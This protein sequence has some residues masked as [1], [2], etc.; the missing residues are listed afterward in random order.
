MA[1][2]VVS[3]V[4]FLC[5]VLVGRGVRAERG[6]LAQTATE[7]V[8]P[9]PAADAWGGS[10]PAG[11]PS[12]ST[13][14]ARGDELSYFNRSRSQPRRWRGS[15]SR[16][17][18]S[19]SRSVRRSRPTGRTRRCRIEP[20]PA[21]CRQSQSDPPSR[22]PAAAADHQTA[23]RRGRCRSGRIGFCR[24]G[25]R[26]ERAQRSGRDRQAPVVEGLRGYVLAPPT[27]RRRSSASAS[28]ASRPG[29]KPTRSR[30]GCRRKSIQALGHS[31]TSVARLR[32]SAGGRFR[33]PARAQL[34]H[35]RSSRASPGSRWR[36]CSSRSSADPLPRA[37]CA[38]PDNRR[39]VLHRH[40]LL[41]HPR[42]GPPTAACRRGSRSSSTRRSIAYLALFPA[43][44]AVI[45]PSDRGAF[46]ARALLAAP[47]RL[48]RDRAGTHL[49]VHRLSVGAARL[50][51]DER[52]AGRA[53]RR[54]CSAS[55][56]SRRWWRAS[57]RASRS[58]ACVS[59]RTAK[60]PPARSRL[61]AGWRRR[62]LPLASV[63]LFAAWGSCPDRR[64]GADAPGRA[65]PGRADS[66]QRRPGREVGSG[67]EPARS[68]R[69]ICG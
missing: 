57:A 43:V 30:R 59:R 56:A 6:D 8:A 64:V 1:A 24:A 2:T 68:S 69:T 35:L 34:S 42:D 49:S 48:G 36:R 3:V 25:R 5:G 67:A 15:T 32:L 18:K 53:A 22:A 50:Q 54:A 10:P 33:C 7:D 51:P 41:D 31:L 13:S 39:G 62:S 38:G 63:A 21:A 19:A 58:V 65:D 4:I 17:L 44:F 46:G 40:A 9:V 23:G 27:A 26:A 61:R 37:F 20:P 11:A 16:R 60:P 52:A 14:A 29:A 55:T 45:V 47:L 66:G 12:Q 28:A